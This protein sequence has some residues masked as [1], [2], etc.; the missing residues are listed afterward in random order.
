LGN[1]QFNCYVSAIEDYTF[2]KLEF[3]VKEIGRNT[4]AGIAMQIFQ[5]RKENVQV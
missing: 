5:V 4:K 1:N 2:H 3:T